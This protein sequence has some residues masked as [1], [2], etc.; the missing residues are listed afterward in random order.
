MVSRVKE[1]Y[2]DYKFE[3]L[4]VGS[5]HY[6]V[7]ILSGQTGKVLQGSVVPNRAKV[8]DEGDEECDKNREG[9]CNKK[10]QSTII[11]TTGATTAKNSTNRRQNGDRE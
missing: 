5:A 10:E 11:T 4:K 2:C 7:P 9:S 3:V 8:N 6:R 1:T